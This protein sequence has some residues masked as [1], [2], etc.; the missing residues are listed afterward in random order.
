MP[1]VQRRVR[2]VQRFICAMLKMR[3]CRLSANLL[4]ILKF[5]FW[6][7][8][9]SQSLSV[10]LGRSISAV[11]AWLVVISTALNSQRSALFLTPSQQYQ[12]PAFIKP[13]ISVAGYRTVISNTSIATIFRLSCA[14]S[15][16][17][18][19]KLK[20]VWFSAQK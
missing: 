11:L 4:L 10:W 3:K 12:M 13:V 15:V 20:R 16:S 8:K 18:W 5:I 7:R 9:V 19:G 17:N 2:S 14:V 1:M 6:T